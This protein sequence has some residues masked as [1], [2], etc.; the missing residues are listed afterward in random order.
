MHQ[1]SSV[2]K[3]VLFLYYFWNKYFYDKCITSHSRC[4][5]M[6]LFSMILINELLKTTFHIWDGF[7]W[8]STEIEILPFY[9]VWNWNDFT[10]IL[11][12][13]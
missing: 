3:E 13:L 2:L 11:N 12:V 5:P 1:I 9:Y 10:T 7:K 6:I 4:I 8:S